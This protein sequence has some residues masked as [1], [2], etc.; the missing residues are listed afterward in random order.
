MMARRP[1]P[2]PGDGVPQ[3]AYA[4]TECIQRRLMAHLR[5]TGLHWGLRRLLQELWIADGLSQAELAHAVRSSEASAS[6]MLKHLVNDGWV[7]R[8]RDAYDY[9]ISRV[10][11]TEKGRALRDA[12]EHE[13]AAIHKEISDDLGARDA[14]RLVT[15][16]GK[17]LDRLL[18]VENDDETSATGI[19]DSP[20]P[21]GVL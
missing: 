15:L 19:Y 18:S 21:P 5:G 10:Y 6:N 1:K 11:L 14:K 4:L 17:A 9:R 20:S 7:E 13:C 16:L 12:I 2:L 8:R 3:A